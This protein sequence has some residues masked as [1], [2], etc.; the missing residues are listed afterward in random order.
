MEQLQ[1]FQNA[2]IWLIPLIIWGS[3][4][5]IIAMWRAGR[6]NDLAWFL[7]IALLNTIGILPIIYLLLQKRNRNKN[8]V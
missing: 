2:L 4:W 5:K 6:N 1:Q 8:I 7:C 3:T